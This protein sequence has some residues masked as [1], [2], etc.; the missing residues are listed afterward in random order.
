MWT[1]CPGARCGD[2]EVWGSLPYRG[3]LRENEELS[4]EGL[5][6]EIVHMSREVYSSAEEVL[7]NPTLAYDVAFGEILADPEGIFEALQPL[8]AKQFADREWVV[9]RMEVEKLLISGSIQRIEE[10]DSSGEAAFALAWF[11]AFLAGMTAV[12]HLRTPTHRRGLILMRELLWSRNGSDL[13]EEVLESLG[14]LNLTP[15]KVQSFQDDFA[16][17][18]DYAVAVNRGRTPFS[19]KLNA[20]IRPYVVDGCQEMIDEGY[21]REAMFWITIGLFVSNLA[22]QVE[23]DHDRKGQFQG[24]FETFLTAL[25]LESKEGI[26]EHASNARFVMEKVISYSEARVGEIHECSQGVEL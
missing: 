15:E 9:A 1:L 11:G 7:S 24:K 17:S 8:V 23:G 22:I 10:A 4:Y 2:R 3:I 12:V 13:Y 26:R 19:F 20:H 16:E 14:Y 18:F 21:H 6:L 25:C 5:M